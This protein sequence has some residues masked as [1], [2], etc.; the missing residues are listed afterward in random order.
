VIGINTAD[1]P[2]PCAQRTD[3]RATAIEAAR[4]AS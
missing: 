2:E 3:L 1:A 4:A